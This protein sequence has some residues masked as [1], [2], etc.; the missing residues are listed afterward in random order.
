MFAARSLERGGRAMTD[1]SAERGH[2]LLNLQ[3]V[4]FLTMVADGNVANQAKAEIAEIVTAW[5]HGRLLPRRE[6]PTV[7]SIFDLGEEMPGP[8]PAPA[9]V[10]IAGGV[11][12]LQKHLVALADKNRGLEPAA[13]KELY[14]EHQVVIAVWPSPDAPGHGFLTLKGA[15]EGLTQFRRGASKYIATMTAIP[16]NNRE[17]AELLQQAFTERAP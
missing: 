4:V 1:D 17:H 9:P 5:W 12:G 11:R 8:E 13:L 16:C 14:N 2:Y 15:T 10:H 3:Q 7:T 6:A